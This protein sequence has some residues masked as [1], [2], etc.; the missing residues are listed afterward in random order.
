VGWSKF[1]EG[2]TMPFSRPT[3][4]QILDRVEGDI[5]AALNITTLLR[6][7]LLKAIRAAIAGASHILHGHIVFVSKQI[8]PDQAEDEY[9]D[10]WGSIY[11]ITRKPATFTQ[12]NIDIVF[13]GAATVPISTVYQRSDGVT[14]TLNAAVTATVAG[15]LPGVLTCTVAGDIGNLDDGQTVTLQSPIANVNSNATVDSTEIVGE[16]IETNESYRQRIVDRIQN[17]PSGG[18]V[19]DYEQYARN[20]AG[21]TRAW[22]LPSYLGQGTVGVTFVVDGETNII[23]IPAKVDEVQVEVNENKPV[24]VEAVVFAPADNAVNFNIAIKPNTAAVQTAIQTEIKDLFLRETQVK[25]GLRNPGAGLFWDGKIPLSRINEA[26]SIA[27]GE[28]DHQLV[29]PT[30]DVQPTA[31]GGILTVG[32]FTFST[33]P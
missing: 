10:R 15:T 33:L 4:Q 12:L 11:G 5:K 25:G 9:L 17:P 32:T 31:N 30:T 2:M 20:V 28:E 6:R 24:G 16:D 22:V 29:S 18:T 19:A 26:I 23:P 21:V 1:K 3:L 14:Y 7:S 8:F 13:T 27:A